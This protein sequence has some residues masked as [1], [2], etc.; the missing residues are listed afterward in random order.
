MR[1]NLRLLTTGVQ[2]P[3]TSK[4]DA[5]DR[6]HRSQVQEVKIRDFSDFLL[7]TGMAELK[8]TGRNCTWSNGHICA[9]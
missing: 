5:D 2:E 1:E 9:R 7:E 6:P 4:G 8:S 3:M